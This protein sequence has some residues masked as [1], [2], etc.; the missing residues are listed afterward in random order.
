LNKLLAI[1]A[2][3]LI[4]AGLYLSQQDSPGTPKPSPGDG[5][6]LLAAFRQN[7]DSAQASADAWAFSC[8]C[9]SLADCIERDASLEPPRLR[10]GV[11]LDDLRLYARHYQRDGH[12][13]GTIYPQL[14]TTVGAHLEQAVGNSG[15]PV[16]AEGRRKRVE[17]YRHLA[18]SAK[19]AASEL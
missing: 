13:Y 4:G 18:A 15:G 3:G 16:S 8:L 17:A 9:Q 10:T 19:Y 7:D 1:V 6:D 2:V 14:K 11:Q 5:P 12:N